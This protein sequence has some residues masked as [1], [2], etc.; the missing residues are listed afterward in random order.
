[1]LYVFE[2]AARLRVS[3]QHVVNLIEEGKLRALNIGGAN[4]KGRRCYRIPVEAWE[5]F[6]RENLL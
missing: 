2:V 6:V 4:P 3:Q 5:T 1:M